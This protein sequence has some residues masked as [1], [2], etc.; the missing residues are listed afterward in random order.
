[1]SMDPTAITTT[2][3]RCIP[4]LAQLL[5]LT[6]SGREPDEKIQFSASGAK[7]EWLA[8]GVMQVSPPQGQ[9]E[10][11]DLVLSA[12][13]H[14][15]EVVPI[16][17]LD[18]LIK[19]I[20]R[21]EV[22]PRARL[23]LM[24]CNPPAMR[25]GVRRVGQDLNRLFCGKHAG[26][27]S[28]E[29]RRA[30]E[31][32][33]LVA[34][35]FDEPDRRR[36]HYDLHSAMRASKLPQFAISPWVPGREITSESLRRLEQAAVDGLLLQHKPSGT[37]SAHTATRHQA[38]AFT[39]EVAEAPDDTWPACLD[40]L[41]QAARDWIEAVEPVRIGQSGSLMK[42]RLAREIVKYSEHFSLLLPADIENFTPIPPGM[43][44]AED[45]NGLSWVVE[46][47]DARILFPMMDVAIGERAGLIVVPLD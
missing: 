36:W 13:V 21:G 35:F 12:G 24:F 40:E 20:G 18:S 17:L 47:R 43:L 41:L 8:E 19:A 6:L 31:L 37:F 7:L 26:G 27:E 2:D 28:D 42:F 22:H 25:Q 3:R 16:K 5:E 39:L 30:S 9:D 29:A 38:E 23:L 44:L 4:V 34:A 10:G 14:G 11:L 15:C 32:E 1:M 33:A 45:E 46:E